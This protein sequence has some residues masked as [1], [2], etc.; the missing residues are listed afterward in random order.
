MERRV[1]EADDH[2]ASIHGAEHLDKILRLHV[3]Q[4]LECAIADLLVVGQDKGLD[5]LLALTEEHVLG[6]AEADGLRAEFEGELGVGGVVGVHADVVGA[7]GIFAQ[8]D[9]VG[10]GEDRIEVSGDLGRFE[11]HRSRGD[12]ALGT[13]DR[14]DV[15]FSEDGFGALDVDRLVG[16]ID[17]E[18]LDTADARSA[19]AARD[20]RGVTRLAAMAR[21]DALGCDHALEVVG[22]RLPAHEDDFFAGCDGCYGI[23]A[24]EDDLAHRGAW[25]RVEA[26]CENLGRR[27]VRELR[28]EQLVELSGVDTRDRLFARDEALGD[29][30]DGDLAG[31]C[32]RAFAHARLEHPE[33]ALLDR[34][35]DVA[36][37]AIVPL[38]DEEDLLEFEGR[39]LERGFG[40]K[41]ADGLGIADARDDVLALCVHQEIAVELTLAVGWIAR[42]RHAGSGRVT[43]VSERHGLNVHGC[44]EVIGDSV[45]LAIDAGALVHPTTEDG[46]D[47]E[48]ELNAGVHGEFRGTRGAE[49]LRVLRCG[50]LPREDRLEF[51]HDGLEVRCRKLGIGADAR[52][53]PGLGEC[54]L[55]EV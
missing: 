1:D 13:V 34:E 49:E 51:I 12:D 21:E 17:L 53:E 47:G 31:G 15:A 32:G 6:A 8:A 33:L 5:D 44:S 29:H 3:E 23:V 7:A 4:L 2:R 41:V 50:D 43:L 14:D 26:A 27:D 22:I 10:P 38:E 35:L 9:L 52:N 37:I 20:H 19:H 24:R 40:L 46:T 45:L 18:R 48:V 55:K 42:E 11:R 28:M 16:G 30:V 36:H 54:V 25:A 39:R